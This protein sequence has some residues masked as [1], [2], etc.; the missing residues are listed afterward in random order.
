MSFFKNIFNKTFAWHL[1]IVFGS[2]ILVILLTF[3]GLDLYTRHGQSFELPDFKGLTENQFSDL[4]EKYDL[5]YSIIDSVYVNDAPPGIVLEQTP[6]AGA[7]VKKN[8]NIFFTINSW[9]PEKVQVPDVID[10]SIRNAR[11]ML[12]SY[13]LEVGELMYVPSEYSNLVLG[14]H[15]QGKPI[16]P[17]KLLERGSTIDLVVGK[18]LSNENTAV[19][20]LI[21]LKREKAKEVSQ[22][23][24]LNIGAEIYDTTVVSQE[25]STD[26]FVWQ[27]RP[28]AS[29]QNQLPLGSSLD[30]WLTTDSSRLEPDSSAVSP[31]D[32]ISKE[33]ILIR[34]ENTPESRESQQNANEESEEEKFF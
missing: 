24:S 6:K 2:G 20:H 10:Y 28:E 9:E 27:Q 12:E 4:I 5:R 33:N 34:E 19:P 17:G 31:L 3:F 7:P 25:D 18:G 11:V 15:Y 13:G 32:S 23:V 30:I 22:N 14:Q 26:A 21:G 1:G 8:R 29:R 16:K